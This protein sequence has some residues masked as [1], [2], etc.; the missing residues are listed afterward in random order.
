VIKNLFTY[1]C[2]IMKKSLQSLAPIFIVFMFVF[3]LLLPSKPVLAATKTIQQSDVLTGSCD[4]DTI[5]VD[6]MQIHYCIFPLAP[7]TDTYQLESGT[8]IMLNTVIGNWSFSGTCE[9]L[10]NTELGCWQI[11]VFSGDTRAVGPVTVSLYVPSQGLATKS[12]VLTISGARKPDEILQVNMLETGSCDTPSYIGVTGIQCKFPFKKRNGRLPASRFTTIASYWGADIWTNDLRYGN[13]ISLSLSD[14]NGQNWQTRGCS[15]YWYPSIGDY[16]M[17]SFDTT[18]ISQPG[19]FNNPKFVESGNALISGFPSMTNLVV[20]PNPNA[21]TPE[22]TDSDGDNLYDAIEQ[23][24]GGDTNNN[25]VLDYQENGYAHF[26]DTES[27]FL[28]NGGRCETLSRT[29]LSENNQYS[30]DPQIYDAY[31]HTM[32]FD[33]SLSCGL[34]ESRVTLD[35]EVGDLTRDFTLKYNK[36]NITSIPSS[37]DDSR[38][39]PAAVSSPDSDN[40][41]FDNLIDIP[42]VTYEKLVKNGKNMVR[43]TYTIVDNSEKDNDLT[44]GNISDPVVLLQNIPVS[45][46][47]GVDPVPTD[48]TVNVNPNGNVQQQPLQSTTK[49]LLIRTGGQD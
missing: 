27:V 20:N 19:V 39:K 15:M 34:S 25:S 14:S 16:L 3:S 17:C 22:N 32:S 1:T 41:Q 6:V 13:N 45:T 35:F 18:G 44:I 33:I 28:V 21:P 30:V 7:T 9:L 46:T 8:G 10:S 4:K 49:A 38:V 11:I 12:P 24:G 37:F 2:N 26:N 47:Q 29:Y 48:N 31:F 43:A 5:Y 36:P 42:D 40:A 23:T